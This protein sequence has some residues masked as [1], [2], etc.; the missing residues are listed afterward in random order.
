[1]SDSEDSP[2]FH[3]DDYPSSNEEEE[4]TYPKGVTPVDYSGSMYLETV[5]AHRKAFVK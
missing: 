3:P 4:D 5:S 2:E 1:M